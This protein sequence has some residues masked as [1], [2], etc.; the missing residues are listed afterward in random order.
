M[1]RLLRKLISLPGYRKEQVRSAYHNDEHLGGYR[2]YERLLRVGT[3]RLAT[4]CIGGVYTRAEARNQGVATALM[5]DAIAYAQAHEYPLLLLDGIPKF[6]HRYG[7]CDVYDLST[8]EFDR[9]AILALAESPYSVRQATLEDATSL[10]TLYERHLG[11]YTGSFERSIE[12]QIHWMQHIKLE[13]LL[14]ATDPADQVR[15]YL[16]LAATQARG[17]FFLAGTQVWEL[18]VDDWPAAAALLQYHVRSG[19]EESDQ[20]ASEII[21]YS[22]PP[23]SPVVQWLGENLEV[24]DISTWDMPVFGWAMREQTFRHQ[25][26]GWMARLVNLSALARAMLPEW[27]ARWQQS[28]AHWSGDISLLIGDEAFTLHIVGEDLQLLNE[29]GNTE[30]T[31][32][33]TP[34]AFTQA[35]FGYCPITRAIQLREHQL[36]S[37]LVTVLTILFPTGRTWIPTSD[38]F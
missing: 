24:I 32:I 20:T 21:R 3:A 35:I 26:A 18:A 27:Q 12:Q 17:P 30:H 14:V 22:I 11:I 23:T 31:F 29:P 36:T 34:Q 25:N 38:W 7:Y 4:G 5:H 1:D 19:K 13:H 28:L 9:Q 6:Y 10:L 15:G 37:D 8:L 2:I 16:F 33:L